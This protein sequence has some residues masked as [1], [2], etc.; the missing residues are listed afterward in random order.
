MN[1]C[2]LLKLVVPVTT[3]IFPL[4]SALRQIPYTKKLTLRLLILVTTKLLGLASVWFATT[5]T[6]LILILRCWAKKL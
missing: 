4:L 3:Q 6:S 1:Q 2:N 5:E